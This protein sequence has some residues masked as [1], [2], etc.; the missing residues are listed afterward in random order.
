MDNLNLLE[1]HDWTF[2]VP[3]A[4]G[5]GRLKEFGTLCANA[6]MTRPLIITDRGSRD[7][8][9]IADI[10]PNPREDEVAAGRTLFR[11]GRHDGI[12]AIGG[13]SGREGGKAVCRTLRHSLVGACV[14]KP[15]KHGEVGFLGKF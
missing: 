7:L 10:S 2:P 14:N 4:Y 9:F 1:T 15:A 3:I 12:I 8:P 6:G 11:N 5:P 13:V